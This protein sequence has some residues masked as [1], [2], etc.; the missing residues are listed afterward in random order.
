MN[1]QEMIEKLVCH[2]LVRSSVGMQMQLG[3]PYME[4]RNGKL[5]V[6]FL[7]HREDFRE[8][9]LVLFAPQYKITW[10]YPFDRVVFFENSLYC[11]EGKEPA[12][13]QTVSAARYAERGRFLLKE[14]Y[15]LCS[16]LL[17]VYE[18]DKAVSEVTLRKYQKAYFETVQAL[19]LTGVYG[20]D[21]K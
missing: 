13:V 1:A 4:K 20:E 11:A 2:P 7:P 5:C 19:D 14:L 6:S 3:I 18:R 12:A 17:A 16:D 8:G 10:V 15:E 21:S 9:N